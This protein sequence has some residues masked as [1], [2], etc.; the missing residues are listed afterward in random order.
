MNPPVS[1]TCWFVFLFLSP[2]SLPSTPSGNPQVRGSH[3]LQGKAQT[4]MYFTRSQLLFWP[5]LLP[6]YPRGPTL[7]ILTYLFCNYV[8]NFCSPP[9]VC[10]G[11]HLAPGENILACPLG[12]HSFVSHPRVLVPFRQHSL[13]AEPTDSGI[14]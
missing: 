6:F 3:C 14:W 11:C 2:S 7:N 4:L 1:L 10:L 9:L 12:V 5:H 13:R 8:V